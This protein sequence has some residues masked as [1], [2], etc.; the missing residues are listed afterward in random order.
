MK[1]IRLTILLV[2]L[3]A[4]ALGIILLTRVVNP[5][6]VIDYSDPSAM[7]PQGT[8]IVFVTPP[9]EIT[10]VFSAEQLQQ[11]DTSTLVRLDATGST[12]YTELEQLIRDNPK[13]QV[14]YQVYLNG[15]GDDIALSPDCVSLDLSDGSYLPSLISL[16]PHLPAL[17]DIRL[18]PDIAEASQADALKDAY[19]E[20]T[21]T[22]SMHL[23]DELYPYE[24]EEV[25]LRGIGHD[26]IQSLQ[27]ALARFTSL[28]IAYLPESENDLSLEDALQLAEDCP[29][30]CPQYMIELFGQSLSMDAERIELENLEIGDSGLDQLRDLLP[31]FRQLQYL[32]LDSCGVSNEA[33]AQLRDDY[34]DIK[35]VWR[36]FFGNYHCLTDTEMIWAT[37]GSVND[38]S[39]KVLKYCTDVKYL[40]LGHNLMTHVDFLSYMPKLEVA[41]L[42][43]SWIEDITPISA[44]TELEYLELFSTRVT[45]FTPL[46]QCTHLKHLNVSHSVNTSNLAI[47]RTDISPLY[48]LPELERFYCTMSNVPQE[49]QDEMIARHPDCEIEFR[50]VDPAEGAW[51]FD[52]NGERNE[53]YA[54]LCEQ[55]GYDTLQQSGKMWSLYG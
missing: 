43:I 27:E 18:A 49:Q 19:P 23:M 14:T 20:A 46:A 37:G 22:Y 42:A 28:K 48:D 7:D 45:D 47:A 33:M 25:T 41:V 34:P 30:V 24:T 44:C 12:C 8:P 13:I 55:F 3:L 11:L 4:A 6:P 26:D 10:A 53:R 5:T 17:K 50:W 31:Y 32:K 38:T 36:V 16:A 52:E 40:D 54:L 35:V 39:S 2:C 21:L 29:V 9:V 15:D 51:R 1:K